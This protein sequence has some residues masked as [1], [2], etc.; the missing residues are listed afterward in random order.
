MRE[1]ACHLP[2]PAGRRLFLVTILLFA[3]TGLF[4]ADLA[5]PKGFDPFDTVLPAGTEHGYS[6]PY[7][8]IYGFPIFR[9]WGWSA[10]GKLAWSVERAIEG[11]GGW[12]VTYNV[13]DLVSDEV[14]WTWTDDSEAWGDGGMDLA[15]G[16][17]MPT[18][19]G[20][21]RAMITA[22]LAAY[23]IKQV[24]V[25]YGGF[26][27]TIGGHGFACR[28]ET[29]P[30]AEAGGADAVMDYRILIRRDNKGEKALTSVRKARAL[31]VYACGFLKSPFENRIA[32][33]IAEERFVFEG[34]E[35]FYSVAGC[36][37]SV[38]F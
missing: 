12:E 34:S 1:W 13:Q 23:G 7:G 33:I 19:Y 28:A 35:L 14:L 11:R 18:S 30:G 8:Q 32:V 25:A 27:A 37:L 16:E 31:A 2:R 10:D 6:E 21:N 3:T 4:S 24:E 20:R 17:V 38:G 29:N 5:L 26:P 36:S 22:K 15:A 9:V